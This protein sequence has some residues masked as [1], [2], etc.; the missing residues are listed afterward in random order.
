MAQINLKRI[1][2]PVEENDGYRVL[3]DRLWPRGISRQRAAIQAWAKDAAPTAELREWFNH[4]P[5]KFAEFKIKY[6]AELKANPAAEA[7]RE[8]LADQSKVT[9]IYGAK[10][11][12]HNQAVVL[13]DFLS[14]N[15]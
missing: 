11:P 1:Y 9:L 5:A 6:L 10:D 13:R 8:K 7:L 14:Q 3:V 2:D 15:G 4:D 12:I